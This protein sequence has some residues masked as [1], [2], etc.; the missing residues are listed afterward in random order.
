MTRLTIRPYNPQDFI[1]IDVNEDVRRG[2][3]GQPIQE[4]AAYHMTHGPALTLIGCEDRIVACVGIHR[5]WEG[6]GELWLVLSADARRYPHLVT[7][8]RELLAYAQAELGYQRLQAAVRLDWPEAIRFVEHMGFA[9]EAIMKHYGPNG[10]DNALYAIVQE[11]A[12]G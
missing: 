2:R 3:A 5:R 10:A 12:N 1:D 4:W 7:A 11:E 6:T 8:I 9:Q